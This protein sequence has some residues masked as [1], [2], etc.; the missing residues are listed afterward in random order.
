LANNPDTGNSKPNSNNPN[1]GL[2]HIV[3]SST[4]PN[5]TKE[6]NGSIST[7]KAVETTTEKIKK[8]ESSVDGFI[9]NA[10]QAVKNISR[11]QIAYVITALALSII[12]LMFLVMYCKDRRNY[13]SDRDFEGVEKFQTSVTCVKAVLIILLGIFFFL[14]MGLEVTYGALVT[15]FTV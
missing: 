7:T 11:I 15:T 6:S 4:M 10:I 13:I 8:P 5:N 3:S 2:E 14:Y 12:A 9:N 1:P